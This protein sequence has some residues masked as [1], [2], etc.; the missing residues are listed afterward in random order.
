MLGS[1][2]GGLEL[3]GVLLVMWEGVNV[4]LGGA[5]M[6]NQW[7]RMLQSSFNAGTDRAVSS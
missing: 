4:D 1:G 6:C 7:F 5:T 2:L 3:G